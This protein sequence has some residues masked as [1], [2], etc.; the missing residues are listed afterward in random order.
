MAVSLL[1][2]AP[3]DHVHVA[4]VVRPA[5]PFAQFP[6]PI[7]D[8]CTAKGLKEGLVELLKILVRDFIGTAAQEH[9][10]SHASSLE[11]PFVKQSGARQGRGRH[12]GER[13][14][15]PESVDVVA[16]GRAEIGRDVDAGVVHRRLQLVG[17]ASQ[18]RRC[19]HER[20]DLDVD[21]ARRIGALQRTFETVG[22]G[23]VNGD[24]VVNTVD[25]FYLSNF[26]FADGPVP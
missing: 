4:S 7:S 22:D 6:L 16:T 15:E 10:E 14:H 13:V 21:C 11:L 3:C 25:V 26:L 19:L 1:V 20:A 5:G 17:D 2:P 23:D 9:G 18:V 12:R 24:G 8:V